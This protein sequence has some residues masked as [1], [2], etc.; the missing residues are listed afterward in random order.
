MKKENINNYYT[1]EDLINFK[2]LNN[3]KDFKVNKS[4]TNE[5]K[6]HPVRY[7]ISDDKHFIKIININKN[8]ENSLSK[9]AKAAKHKNYYYT[10][11]DFENFNKLKQFTAFNNNESVNHKTEAAQTNTNYTPNDVNAFD[12]IIKSKSGTKNDNENK[13]NLKVDNKKIKIIDYNKLKER[14]KIL[15]NKVGIEKIKIVYFD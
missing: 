12:Q 13:N 4:N 10:S 9:E 1:D 5:N 6:S 2:K 15:K 7:A 8:N 3:F 11:L 14:E